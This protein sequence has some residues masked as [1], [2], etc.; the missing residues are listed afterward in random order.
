MEQQQ[1]ALNIAL[2]DD[3]LREVFGKTIAELGER[4]PQVVVLDA[5]VAGGTGA[6]HFRKRYPDRF[7]Q[8]GIAEQNMVSVASGMAAMGFIPV[9]TTFAVFSL[10]AY[11]QTRLSIAYSRRN[12]KI[13]ASHPGL[14]VGPDGASAQCLEDI[15][16]Y[17]A[18]PNMCVIVPAD[19][20]E[21]AQVVAA[22]LAESGPMYIRTGRSPTNNVLPPDYRF[23]MGRGAVLREGSDVTLIA[24]GVEL[25][26]A[27]EAAEQLAGEGIQ[28]RVVNMSSIKPIDRDLIARC[29]RETGAIVTAEDHNIIGG[30]GGAVAEVLAQTCPVP[31]ELVGVQDKFGTSGD[32]EELAQFYGIDAA[33]IAAAARRVLSRKG[34]K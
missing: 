3:S 26:R 5:D 16:A 33:G 4:M 31:Q 19:P 25:R 9:V 32:P 30:L 10:R 1:T 15:A 17:R 21:M 6:H 8:C 20:L 27:F 29:A 34:G 28:A 14:D 2:A 11:E 12:V 22:A 7:I 18:L 24:C 23:R 13:F